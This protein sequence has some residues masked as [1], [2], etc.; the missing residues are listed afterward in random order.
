MKKSTNFRGF[1]EPKI[2]VS[3]QSDGRG[4]TTPYKIS[5]RTCWGWCVPRMG[6]EWVMGVL[7]RNVSYKIGDRTAKIEAR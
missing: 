5:D 1:S 7:A 6:I 3:P 2:K 4:I